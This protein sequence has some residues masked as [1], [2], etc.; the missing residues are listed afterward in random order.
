MGPRVRKTE[1]SRSSDD[2]TM[3]DAERIYDKRGV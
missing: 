3:V 2:L 1:S